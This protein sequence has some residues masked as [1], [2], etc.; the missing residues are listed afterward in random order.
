[1]SPQPVDIKSLVSLLDDPDGD[2]Y[3]SVVSA[4]ME[5][6]EDAVPYLEGLMEETIDELTV[7][8]ATAV[9]SKLYFNRVLAAFRGWVAAGASDLSTGLLLLARLHNKDCDTE[10]LSRDMLR[11]R[12]QIWLEC[13]QFLTP[14]EQINVFL[15][16]LF[17]QRNIKD[18]RLLFKPEASKYFS[19]E[20]VLLRNV[21]SELLIG[22]LYQVY[23]D[24]FEIPVR[25]FEVFPNKFYAAYLSDLAENKDRI[26]CFIYPSYGEVF[27]YEDMQESLRVLK[28]DLGNIR[29]LSSL[30][31]MKS[32]LE[33]I[34]LQY[35]REHNVLQ[36]HQVNE[37]LKLLP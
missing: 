24:V 28:S 21:G 8:R 36:A 14:L 13:N 16:I 32:L 29:K 9:L 6:G 4:I 25:L 1:M 33:N 17:K 19:L 18:F 27:S 37:L 35:A 31:I 12:R 23:F 20:T 5:L 10:M 22:A 15:N 3:N 11:I 26:L 30:D 7:S 2:V 34:A